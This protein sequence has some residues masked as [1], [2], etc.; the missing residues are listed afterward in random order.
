MQP[1]LDSL[2]LRLA[3]VL[4]RQERQGPCAPPGK[5][6]E[7]DLVVRAPAFRAEGVDDLFDGIIDRADPRD[8]LDEPFGRADKDFPKD[9]P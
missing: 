8:A 4:G 7:H 3:L 6:D 5:L 2:Y 1:R 9:G